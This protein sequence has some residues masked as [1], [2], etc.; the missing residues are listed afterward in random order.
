MLFRIFKMI[1]TSGFLAASECT[2]HRPMISCALIIWNQNHESCTI[3]YELQTA[4]C[5]RQRGFYI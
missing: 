3:R 5:Y 2:N 1:A 4:S